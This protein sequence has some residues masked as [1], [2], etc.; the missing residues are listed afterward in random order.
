MFRQYRVTDFSG[1][2]DEHTTREFLVVLNAGH[3]Y[4]H[5]YSPYENILVR[6][7]VTF[8]A[9]SKTYSGKLVSCGAKGNDDCF[10]KLKL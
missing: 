6:V 5:G 4:H 7:C 8:D 2:N 1:N 3:P 9:V 10:Q